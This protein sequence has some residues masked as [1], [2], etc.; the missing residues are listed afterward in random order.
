MIRHPDMP[1]IIIKMNGQE[2]REDIEEE[3]DSFE[4]D[5]DDLYLTRPQDEQQVSQRTPSHISIT[6]RFI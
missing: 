1:N 2:V 5:L 3:T 6:F 4:P